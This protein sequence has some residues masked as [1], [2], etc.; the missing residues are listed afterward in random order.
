MGMARIPAAELRVQTG[1]GGLVRVDATAPARTVPENDLK[2]WIKRSP[3]SAGA[4]IG[5]GLLM[6]AAGGVGAV[7]MHVGFFGV[8]A[9]GSMIT[10][11]GGLA[12][13]GVL[14]R[15][16]R[17]S[18]DDTKALPPA[19]AA[20]VIAERSRRVQQCLDKGGHYTFEQ[21]MAQLRWTEGAL[22]ETLVAMKDGGL[23][24]E[25]L[26]LE[27]GEWFYRSQV[28][29]YGTGG[30]MTLADRQAQQHVGEAR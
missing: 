16:G 25:D 30:A 19:S 28:A 6:M 22:L 2:Q 5:G 15:G 18:D 17:E 24:V 4:L 7:V 29:T 10:L 21:L 9:L 11:G 12:F 8:V 27:T 14:K 3:V 13:L 23:L 20:A 1:H 26:D